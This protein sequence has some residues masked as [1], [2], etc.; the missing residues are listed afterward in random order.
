VLTSIH[1]SKWITKFDHITKPIFN[2]TITSIFILH[3]S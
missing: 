2:V 3:M 1:L